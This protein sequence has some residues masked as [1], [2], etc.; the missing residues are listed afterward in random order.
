MS[1]LLYHDSLSVS[2]QHNM[3]PHAVNPASRRAAPGS[4]IVHTGGHDTPRISEEHHPQTHTPPIVVDFSRSS[5][6]RSERSRDSDTNPSTPKHGKPGDQPS[7]PRGS[8]EQLIHP[9]ARHGDQPDAS[10]YRSTLSAPRNVRPGSGTSSKGYASDQ[11]YRSAHDQEALT[12]METPRF[13]G[14]KSP[15]AKDGA[16][17]ETPTSIDLFKPPEKPISRNQNSAFSRT[18][19]VQSSGS[20]SHPSPPSPNPLPSY[21]EAVQHAELYPSTQTTRSPRNESSKDTKS[22]RAAQSASSS[23]TRR[24]SSAIEPAQISPRRSSRAAEPPSTTVNFSAKPDTGTR[25]KSS[26][27]QS[28]SSRRPST[29]TSSTR[30]TSQREASSSPTTQV[31]G[32][33]PSEPTVKEE[34]PRYAGDDEGFFSSVFSG[35]LNPTRMFQGGDDDGQS[36]SSNSKGILFFSRLAGTGRREGDT[37]SSKG[38]STRAGSKGG[39]KT[40]GF[41]E[42]T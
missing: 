35:S 25:R 32:R 8:H 15:R 20:I 19:S 4:L 41:N 40:G 7:T 38:R 30:R 2:E 23:S 28:Q 16:E 3:H 14:A 1:R 9:Q 26:G 24:K 39:F 42:E 17:P 37:S 10:A 6:G 12:D 34:G 5:P 22:S 13:P 29:T 36:K 11:G 27:T 31:K 18:Q 21:T 33:K